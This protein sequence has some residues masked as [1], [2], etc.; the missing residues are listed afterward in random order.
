MCRQILEHKISNK[1]KKKYMYYI[2][3]PSILNSFN[4]R[5]TIKEKKLAYKLYYNILINK[6]K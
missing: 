1:I 3:I 2:K 6:I 5:T 4:V